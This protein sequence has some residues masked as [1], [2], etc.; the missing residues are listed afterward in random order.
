M[1][2]RMLNTIINILFMT[3]ILLL[4][5]FFFLH[6]TLKS[7]VNEVNFTT[8][9]NVA[10]TGVFSDDAYTYF[11]NQVYKYSGGS[12]FYVIVKYEKKIK[13]GVY[14]TYWKK[15][16]IAPGGSLSSYTDDQILTRLGRPVPMHIG[17]K[18]TI[19]LESQDQTLFVKLL[20]VPLFG[21]LNEQSDMR[22]KS[23]KTVVVGSNAQSIVKGYELIAEIAEHNDKGWKNGI[24]IPQPVVVRVITEAR[25]KEG[26]YAE[27]GLG[28]TYQIY[29]VNSINQKYEGSTL[30]RDHIFDTADFYRQVIEYY[31]PIPAGEKPEKYEK[32]IEF[33]QK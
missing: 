6:E 28:K 12:N 8:L 22:I 23:T 33:T 13:P 2:G 32:V 30:G 4:I 24:T 21:L 31:G 14:T 7:N 29:D 27:Y 20:N 16:N 11:K 3:Y 26:T 15:E 17:D 25:A 18:V 5:A 1:I 19:Y 10:T 9:D